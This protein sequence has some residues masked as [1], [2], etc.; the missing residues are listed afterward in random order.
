MRITSGVAQALLRASVRERVAIE[1]S[2]IFRPASTFSNYVVYLRKACFS[3]ERS[4]ARGAPAVTNI[5]YASQLGAKGKYVSPNFITSSAIAQIIKRETR[6]GP[7]A[8]LAY[9]SYLFALRARS[10]SLPI[11]REFLN[12]DM[13]AFPPMEDQALIAIR[14]PPE[15]RRLA[16]RL[17]PSKNLPNGRIMSRHCL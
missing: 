12:D 5:V 10:G 3:P 16:P 14:C 9:L 11:R 2:S 15:A 8:Q 7:V 1:R 13:S 4:I 6:D 17:R